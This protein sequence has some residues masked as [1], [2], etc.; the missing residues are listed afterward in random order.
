MVLRLLV[1]ETTGETAGEMVLERVGAVLRLR[2]ADRWRL[3]AFALSDFGDG[4]ERPMVAPEASD[5]VGTGGNRRM[6]LEVVPLVRVG[7][8]EQTHDEPWLQA[9]CPVE[10]Q[11]EKSHTYPHAPQ[12]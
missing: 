3:F 2:I 4:V 11:F 7:V 6:S 10:G 9:P 5:C 12:L 1:G 8:A